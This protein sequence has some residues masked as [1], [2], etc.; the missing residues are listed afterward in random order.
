MS[1]VIESL[2]KLKEWNKYPTKEKPIVMDWIMDW[3]FTDI[4][5]RKDFDLFFD[6]YETYFTFTVIVEKM[7]KEEA[8]SLINKNL[9][10]WNDRAS[11]FD[12]KLVG[13]LERADSILSECIFC[14]KIKIKNDLII[15]DT[16][17]F[18]LRYDEFPVTEGHILIISKEHRPDFSD[19]TLY[20]KMNL[21]QA[22]DV[23]REHLK[24]KYGIINYNIGINNG[25]YAGQTIEHFHCHIIPRRKDDVDDPRGGVRG[26]IP[27][28]QKY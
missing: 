4:L 11:Y 12:K 17:Y 27:N 18:V 6:V 8:L 19:L 21:T 5:I 22:I 2:D 28:K 13:F 9:Q 3:F 16:Q 15:T 23:A 24:M 26:I 1:I 14:K 10:Y 25:E 20:E 7:G